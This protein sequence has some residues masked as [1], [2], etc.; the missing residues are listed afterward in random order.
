[1]LITDRGLIQEITILKLTAH[2]TE[3]I[4]MGSDPDQFLE[5]KY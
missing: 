2:K 1:M 4:P 3:I 5:G